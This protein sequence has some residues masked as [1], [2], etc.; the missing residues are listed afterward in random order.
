MALRSY[1]RTRRP[2]QN[3]VYRLEALGERAL[4]ESAV[5]AKRIWDGIVEVWGKDGS[6]PKVRSGA[7]V[8]EKSKLADACTPTQDHPSHCCDLYPLCVP[9][10]S[11]RRFRGALHI[12]AA[13]LP[14]AVVTVPL[15]ILEQNTPDCEPPTAPDVRFRFVLSF[16]GAA[17]F[18]TPE[19]LYG[20]WGPVRLAI[21]GAVIV[22][23]GS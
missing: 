1:A 6:A 10:G 14:D 19:L 4:E 21:P 8:S 12:A 11:A 5:T 16:Y 15:V 7:N 18:K 13:I 23:F 17:W 22:G 2:G 9:R 20:S 3:V